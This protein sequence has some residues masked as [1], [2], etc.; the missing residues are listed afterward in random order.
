M[1]ILNLLQQKINT[2]YRRGNNGKRATNAHTANGAYNEG[3]DMAY[4]LIKE[5]FERDDVQKIITEAYNDFEHALEAI[6]EAGRA[7]KELQVI[8]QIQ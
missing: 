6:D 8:K 7:Y 3:L 2:H 5:I 4:E 1:Q